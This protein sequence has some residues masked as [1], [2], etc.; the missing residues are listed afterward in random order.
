MVVFEIETEVEAFL[1]SDMERDHFLPF[2]E[3]RRIGGSKVVWGEAGA[4]T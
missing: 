4:K 3:Q 2:S 1:H